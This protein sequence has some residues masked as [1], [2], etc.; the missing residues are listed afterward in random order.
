MN[1]SRERMKEQIINQHRIRKTSITANNPYEYSLI[2]R[3][4][5]SFVPCCITEEGEEL[6]LS[7]DVAGLKAF[8]ELRQCSYDAKLLSL[9]D[10]AVLH[11]YAVRLKFSLCPDNLYYDIYHKVCIGFR[12]IYGNDEAYDEGEFIR[13]YKALIGDILSKKYTY[14]DYYEGGEDLYRKSAI[15]RKISECKTVDDIEVV[16]A[17]EYE[18]YL[19]KRETDYI[20]VSRLKSLVVR[21]ALIVLTALLLGSLTLTSYFFYYERPYALA[22]VSSYDAWIQSDYEKTFVS[23][24]E[25]PIERLNQTQKYI[26]AYSAIKCEGFSQ[27]NLDGILNTITINGDAKLKDYWICIGRLDTVKAADIAMQLSDDQLLYYAYLREKAIV[28]ADTA[29]TGEEKAAKLSELDSKLSPLKEE[30]EAMLKEQEDKIKGAG[31]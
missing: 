11:D 16:L 29:I 14:A 4:K 9:I 7:Y 5:G 30:Y 26:L 19:R 28:E 20:C 10:V 17:Q 23:M 2:E 13:E 1:E 31:E 21:I 3:A 6:L 25:I 18:T 12:D 8:D 27:A 15:L 24:S 22:S